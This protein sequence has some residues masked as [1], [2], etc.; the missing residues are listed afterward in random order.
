MDLP[1]RRLA[2]ALRSPAARPRT[3]DVALAAGL[4]VAGV[5][6]VVVTV[7]HPSGDDAG[8]L[9]MP[10]P[11]GIGFD[12]P[13]PPIPGVPP[14]PEEHVEWVRPLLVNLFATLPVAIRRRLP[15][16]AFA[17]ALTGVFAIREGLVLPGFVGILMCAYSTVAYGRRL[18]VALGMLLVAAAAAAA[19]FDESIP[20]MPGW[21]TPFAVLAPIGL[22]AATIRST[23]DR[24]VAA[25]RRADAVVRERDAATRAAIA[26]ERA[27]IARELHDLV[28]HHVSVMVIQAGGAGKILDSRP[29]LVAAAL[30]AIE[31]SG[32][33]A[34]A[35]LRH[36][37]GLIAPLDDTLR[38]QPGLADLDA[39]AGSVRAAGQPVTLD[40]VDGAVPHGMEL[41]VYRIV[42][43]GLTN[44]MRHAPGAR[45]TVHIHRENASTLTVRV[46]NEAPTDL[47]GDWSG[48]WRGVRRAEPDWSEGPGAG[49]AAPAGRGS[50]TTAARSEGGR[51][52][53]GGGAGLVGL[54]ERLR[55]LGGTLETRRRVGGGFELCARI[56]VEAGATDGTGSTG[57]TAST[58]TTEGSG[59]TERTGVTG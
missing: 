52:P 41:T 10:F 51:A 47:V 28:S 50:E 48:S 40:R 4:A 7:R 49:H 24:A 3:A 30:A 6:W 13:P 1:V 45:T 21:L 8:P 15:Y 17:A 29:D 11:P 19:A 34:M 55:L 14:Q 44:A 42:Q 20:S 59:T 38:P 58:G 25:A 53:E 35:E 56:P 9:K 54:R 57:A 18:A 37:L 16:L 33:D 46:R 32:R 36:L 26:E 12:R 5:L 2:A 27:H 23:R 39:L 31:A 43:E 22:A